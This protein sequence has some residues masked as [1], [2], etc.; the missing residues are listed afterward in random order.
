MP[1]PILHRAQLIV[2]QAFAGIKCV[3]SG[4]TGNLRGT[5][6]KR[7]SGVVCEWDTSRESFPGALA[8]S[9]P[10]GRTGSLIHILYDRVSKLGQLVQVTGVLLGHV[11]AHEMR[12]VLAIQEL[13]SEGSLMK[14]RLTG[15]DLEQILFRHFAFDATDRERIYV[16]LAVLA[17]RRAARDRRAN[18]D[19]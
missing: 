7:P 17:S 4:E 18:R 19:H 3:S 14:A 13:H 12:H 11:L 1:L 15:R 6:K 5:R 10:Y 16:G 9:Q 2:I 8:Y